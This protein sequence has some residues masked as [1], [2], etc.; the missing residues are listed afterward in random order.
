M[1]TRLRM[2]IVLAGYPEPVVNL[3]IRDED[4]EWRARLDLC[5]PHLRLVIEYDGGHH[6][7][8]AAQWSSDLKR[9]EWLEGRGWRVVVLN[10]DAFYNEPLETLRRIRAVMLE[11]GQRGL[12]LRPPAAWTRQF[13]T[14]VRRQAATGGVIDPESADQER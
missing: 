2:L 11:R 6:R 12:P 5:Y 13:A 10:S 8:D 7:W 9:R 4:G 14:P 1:E 3:I